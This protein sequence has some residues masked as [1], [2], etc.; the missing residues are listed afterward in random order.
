MN[1]RMNSHD[2]FR[3]KL[4]SRRS[5]RHPLEV[6]PL[7][8]A[9]SSGGVGA[10]LR[11]RLL[12]MFTGG[13][14]GF[15]ATNPGQGAMMLELTKPPAAADRPVSA[16]D[17]GKPVSLVHCCPLELTTN[18]EQAATLVLAA[19]EAHATLL[20][21]HGAWSETIRSPTPAGPSS[22]VYSADSSGS[23]VKG[24]S[25]TDGNATSIEAAKRDASFVT[26]TGAPEDRAL[27]E[28]IQR[29]MNSDANEVFTFGH[30]ESAI[31]HFH[32]NLGTA[33]SEAGLGDA[34]V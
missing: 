7:K 18:G 32:R 34:D 4:P 24:T 17:C 8:R 28:S 29:T 5:R 11:E 22:R 27:A 9:R 15:G 26:Q 1:F 21:V 25:R 23:S 12:T 10:R 20:T 13:G 16:L 14:G 30:F 19:G 2:L 6:P 33:L 31:V 3:Y